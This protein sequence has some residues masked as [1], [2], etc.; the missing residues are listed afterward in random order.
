MCADTCR[1]T[2]RQP[3]GDSRKRREM[4]VDHNCATDMNDDDDRAAATACTHAVGC[5]LVHAH[6]QSDCTVLPPSGPVEPFKLL[7][8]HRPGNVRCDAHQPRMSQ[9]P[10]ARPRGTWPVL[11]PYVAAEL[12]GDGP[13]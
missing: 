5:A 4:C 9:S 10:D 3:T 12:R 2:P 13:A 11:K 8:V 6:C 1:P 7:Y